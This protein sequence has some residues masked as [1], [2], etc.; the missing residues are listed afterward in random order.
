MEEAISLSQELTFRVL[1]Q[2]IHLHHVWEQIDK[3]KETIFIAKPQGAPPKLVYHTLDIFEGV[4]ERFYEPENYGRFIILLRTLS[5]DKRSNYALQLAKMLQGVKIGDVV[6]SAPKLSMHKLSLADPGWSLM[7]FL[8]HDF[9]STTERLQM[10][11]SPLTDKE[12][13]TYLQLATLLG[14]LIS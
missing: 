1:Q 13:D 7:Q 9:F 12:E 3:S 2:A 6:S 4:L 11:E 10:N 5:G 14:Q 8:L